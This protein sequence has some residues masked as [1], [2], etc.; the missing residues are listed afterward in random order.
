MIWAPRS[1]WKVFKVVRA[2]FENFGAGLVS[3]GGLTAP[4][5]LDPRG[6]V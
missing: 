4:R 6:A 3:W 2:I 5:Q 1:I